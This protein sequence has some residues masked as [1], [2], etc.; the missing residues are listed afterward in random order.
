MS[1]WTSCKGGNCEIKF[2]CAHAT[3]RLSPGRNSRN[4]S[5]KRQHSLCYA[6]LVTVVQVN[7]IDG[8]S[9]DMYRGYPQPHA[10]VPEHHQ[11]AR[12]SRGGWTALSFEDADR[13]GKL[14]HPQNMAPPEHWE[15]ADPAGSKSCTNIR[16]QIAGHVR[17]R[18]CV[19]PDCNSGH[20]HV[21]TGWI[22]CP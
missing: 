2:R 16:A 12:T 17:V 13:N 9:P 15:P 14:L 22:W 11:P 19:V 18:R 4:V 7:D 5:A 6:V 20:Q 3:R 8:A 1:G 21:L 10:R